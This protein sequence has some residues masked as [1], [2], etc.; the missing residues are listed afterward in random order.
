MYSAKIRHGT[1]FYC[2]TAA[3]MSLATA[4]I[5]APLTVYNTGVDN[6]GN[7][8]G[9]GGVPDIHYGLIVQPGSAIAQTV[10]DTAYPFPPWIAN[11]SGSRW[12]GPDASSQG[13]PGNYIY[14]TTFNVPANPIL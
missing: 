11:N 10:T 9:S 1:L 4:I 8:W 14:R 5:A 12:I 7:A 13:P 3:A 6:S 2:A